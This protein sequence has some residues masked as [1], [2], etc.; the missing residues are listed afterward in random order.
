MTPDE[1]SAILIAAIGEPDPL[2][3][4]IER[5]EAI[6]N[7]VGENPYPYR[8]DFIRDTAVAAI[9]TMGDRAEVFNQKYPGDSISAADL[10]DIT[11]TALNMIVKQAGFAGIRIKEGVITIVKK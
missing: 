3:A 8:T 10:I 11:L 2:R 5:R 4:G 1:I 7:A 6:R 9:V